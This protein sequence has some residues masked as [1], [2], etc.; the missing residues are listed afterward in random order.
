MTVY[1]KFLAFLYNLIVVRLNP[2][3]IEGHKR[4]VDART[5]LAEALLKGTP[6]TI[7]LRRS[8]YTDENGAELIAVD[9]INSLSNN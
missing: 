2:F 7:A 9:L 3:F 1:V 4:P 6:M 8:A 5:R